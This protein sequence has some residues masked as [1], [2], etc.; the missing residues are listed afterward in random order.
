ML[1]KMKDVLYY[2]NKRLKTLQEIM[3]ELLEFIDSFIYF[4]G[5]ISIH[6]LAIFV[7]HQHLEAYYN[8]CYMQISYIIML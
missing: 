7:G 1:Q 4:H 2:I 8:Q 3:L 6:I 5:F